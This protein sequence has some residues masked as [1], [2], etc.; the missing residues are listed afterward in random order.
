MSTT[1]L[2]MPDG[3]EPR[4]NFCGTSENPFLRNATAA[5]HIARVSGSSIAPVTLKTGANVRHYKENNETLNSN[6]RVSY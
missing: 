5:H 1:R 2:L 6:I 3:T 4:G